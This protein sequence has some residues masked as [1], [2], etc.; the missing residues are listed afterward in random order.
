MDMGGAL[1]LHGEVR[2]T[3]TISGHGGGTAA[4]RS[5]SDLP[6]ARGAEA[7]KAANRKPEAGWS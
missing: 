2:L 1:L 5:G 4:L 3:F 6:P 7:P